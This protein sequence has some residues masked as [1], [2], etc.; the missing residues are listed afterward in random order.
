MARKPTWRSEIQQR[1]GIDVIQPTQTFGDSR[2]LWTT[3][4]CKIKASNGGIPRELY[5]SVIP[6]RFLQR[7]ARLGWPHA[8]VSDLYGLHFPEVVL[9]SYDTAPSELNADERRELGCKI[10]DQARARG[11]DS[12]HFYNNSPVLSRPYFEI[13][14]HTGLPL[15]FHTQLP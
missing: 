1:W 8:I 6:Q 14:A 4:C 15:R 12:I 3:R 2:T 5:Q 9:P 13:L 7:M 10:A 11:F